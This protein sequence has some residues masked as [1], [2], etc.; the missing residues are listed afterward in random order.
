MPLGSID[1]W[2]IQGP[3]R[4][5]SALGVRGMPGRPEITFG[6]SAHGG[7]AIFL[8]DPIPRWWW[9]RD[10]REIYLTVDDL[11]GLATE[12]ER[13]GI[14][15]GWTCAARSRSRRPGRS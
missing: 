7:V 1:R 13:R 11:E 12:L 4:W 10:L 6:G 14:P 3:Y 5:W 2:E 8:R 15:G 9:I